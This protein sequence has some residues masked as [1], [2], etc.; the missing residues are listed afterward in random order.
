V[1]RAEEPVRGMVSRMPFTSQQK[2]ISELCSKV[3]ATNDP[4]EFAHAVCELRAALRTQLAYLTE[5][6]YD[7]KQAIAQLPA[8]PPSERRKMER[9]RVRPKP[10]IPSSAA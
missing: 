10:G 2:R 7:A 9:R 1:Y 5:L 3:M 8:S 6:V 4:A